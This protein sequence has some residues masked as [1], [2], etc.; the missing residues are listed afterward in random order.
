MAI[1]EA[2]L[3]A[4]L[5]KAE[6]ERKI[7]VEKTWKRGLVLGGVGIAVL[8]G[9]LV[10]GV[11]PLGGLPSIMVTAIAAIILIS[12]AF[13]PLAKW[14]KTARGELLAQIA[15]AHGLSFE[16]DAPLEMT[17]AFQQ[18]S[19]LPSFDKGQVTDRM[20][21][22]LDEVP[23][24]IA[25]AHLKEVR[26]VPTRNGTRRE[27]VTVFR[28]LIGRFHFQ[29]PFEGRTLILTDQGWLGNKLT[30]WGR[31]GDRVALEDPTFEKRF[32][33]YGSDQVEARR[34]LTPAFMERLYELSER[35]GG[36][37]QAAFSGQDLSLTV[38]TSKPLAPR[39]KRFEDMHTQ[40]DLEAFLGPI[41]T[42]EEIIDTLKLNS[43]TRI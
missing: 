4:W 2:E 16:A 9:L 30:G 14:Q 7:A 10:F 35:L 33:V 20:S 39:L 3:G 26:H 8:A 19:L 24:E 11:V 12:L 23:V 37:L 38:K 31:P 5:D 36:S 13:G 32:E 17:Q 43:K 40:L 22:S 18:D 15:T 27:E 34:L 42:I 25:I 6:A 41:H 28:G 21:G 29:K 1:N